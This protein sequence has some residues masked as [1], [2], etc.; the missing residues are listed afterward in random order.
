MIKNLDKQII[1]VT[2]IKV[3]LNHRKTILKSNK[4]VVVLDEHELAMTI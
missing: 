1:L 4:D 2:I 3:I